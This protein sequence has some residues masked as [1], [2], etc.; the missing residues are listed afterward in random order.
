MNMNAGVNL[1]V[2]LDADALSRLM[3]L[4]VGISA[5]GKIVSI[6]PTLAKLIDGAAP[7]KAPFLKVFQVRRPAGITTLDDLRAHA[8]QRLHLNLRGRGEAFRG[9]AVPTAEGGVLLNLSF[10]IRLVEVVRQHALTVDDFAAT[11]LAVEML[12]LVEV[13]TAVMAEL[14]RLNA[15]LLG[16]KATAELQALTD[17]LTGLYNRRALDSVLSTLIA[18]G[19]EFGL[20]HI[21][22]DY[23][24]QV[25]DTL[26][27][28]AG[29]QVL[30]EVAR[31]LNEET[32]ASDTVSRVGGDEFVV[33]LPGLSDRVPMAQIARRI[34]ERLL[35]PIDFEGKPCQIAAS[36]GM[37]ISSRYEKPDPEEMLHDADTALYASK[38][39]GRSQ[40]RFFDAGEEEAFS[41]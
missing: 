22:L 37:T 21:D 14:K 20:M 35:Q 36:I 34:I 19:V 33:L 28:A 2:G 38:R 30:R 25:N 10:G 15:R 18:Q 12:Y 41:A 27:H 1:G 31:A 32:R 16:A 17:T 8:G 7:L 40:A 5:A 4:H 3:P 11:D 9:L 29:D 24:K 6:G 23:F 13:K 26:G 39:G